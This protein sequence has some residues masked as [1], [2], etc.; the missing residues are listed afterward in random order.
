MTP[1]ADSASREKL[2]FW[3]GPVRVDF[4]E[5]SETEVSTLDLDKYIDLDAKVVESTSRNVKWDWGA[6]LVTVDAPKVQALVGFLGRQGSIETRFMKVTVPV[7]YASL[8]LVPL[9][10]RPLETSRRMLLQIF[11]EDSNYGWEEALGDDNWITLKNLG[12]PPVVVR[13]IAG[14]VSLKH[15]DA[16]T[17]RVTALNFNGYPEMNEKNKVQSADGFSLNPAT[18]YY[19]I[20]A[21]D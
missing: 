15:K 18:F 19:L 21:R 9:D 2:A 5:G 12:A 14:R 20:E 7:E 4:Q 17:L 3:V 10:D 1:F 6:G 13:E 11:T 8:A 16:D